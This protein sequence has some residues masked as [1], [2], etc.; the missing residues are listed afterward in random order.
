MVS[1]IFSVIQ[2]DI[3][4]EFSLDLRRQLVE[5]TLASE[6]IRYP[7]EQYKLALSPRGKQILYFI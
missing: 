2:H 3:T 1:S 4:T 6:N 5:L 7:Y